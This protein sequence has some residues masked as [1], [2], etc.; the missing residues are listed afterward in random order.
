MTNQ[1]IDDTIITYQ[2]NAVGNISLYTIDGTQTTYQYNSGQMLTHKSTMNSTNNGDYFSYTYSLDGNRITAEANNE[3]KEYAYDDLGR[4]TYESSEISVYV[5]DCTPILTEDLYT[6]DNR[7]NRLTKSSNGSITR[8]EYDAN[9][10]LTCESGENGSISYYYD[11][12]GNTIVK[13]MPI[14][15]DEGTPSI[16]MSA[17]EM[18][19]TYY[20]YDPLN[21]LKKISADGQDISYTYGVNN[22]RK[23]KTVNGLTKG[24]V[25][26]NSKLVAET[27]GNAI[28]IIHNYSL[29]GIAKT[30]ENNEDRFYITTGHEDV[31]WTVYQNGELNHGYYYDAFGNNLWNYQTNNLETSMNEDNPF[32][33]AGEYRDDETDFIYL[34][35]RYYAPSNGRFIT[36]DPIKDGL[37]WYAYCGGNPVAFV[38]PLGLYY[39]VIEALEILYKSKVMMEFLPPSNPLYQR[40]YE[41]ALAAKQVIAQDE[42]YIENWSGLTPILDTIVNG[43]N[44]SSEYINFVKNVVITAKE[45]NDKE[46]FMDDVAFVSAFILP[47]VAVKAGVG[48]TAVKGA[49]KIAP[50]VP[51]IADISQQTQQHIMQPKHEW[52]RVVADPNSWSEVSN[53]INTVMTKGAESPY[54]SALQKSLSVGGEIVVVT[55]KYVNEMIRISD[56]WVQTK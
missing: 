27:D 16:S 52:W 1:T 6:Y 34:R 11:N 17:T 39:D 24:Y 22:L 51:R 42:I 23:T 36:E 38:D 32:Q 46:H 41:Q 5:G 33:Y 53:I 45:E 37:N 15:T 2:Y 54:G 26:N 18:N 43:D 20:E 3:Y 35:N 49:T 28:D 13:N 56:A 10:R 21:R 9:N 44:N 8:Y 29:D 30:T 25:W 12:N 47:A 55:Y 40:T 19:F 31:R 50:A 48:A 7:G 14:L 4:L